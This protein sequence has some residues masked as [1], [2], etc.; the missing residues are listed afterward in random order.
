MLGELFIV[1]GVP[2]HTRSDN[3]SKFIAK[4]VQDWIRPIESRSVYI[5]PCSPWKNGYVDSFDARLREE[6]LN[7]DIIYVLK[8]A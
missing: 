8:E 4:S 2:E 1:H 3:G 6:L 5:K 7:S